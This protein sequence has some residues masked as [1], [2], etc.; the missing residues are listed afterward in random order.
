MSFHKISVRSNSDFTPHLAWNRISLPLFKAFKKAWL[1]LT[2]FRYIY[3]CVIE[4]LECRI[5]WPKA[6]LQNSL[7]WHTLGLS[8]R[9]RVWSESIN[10]NT[11]CREYIHDPPGNY[12][13][14]HCLV[15]FYKTFW[16]LYFLLKNNFSCFQV[17]LWH[18]HKFL[19][20]LNR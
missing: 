15:G 18:I 11:G 17:H 5:I 10:V 7:S 13:S 20:S 9:I 4:F 1:K 2:V 16:K 6:S 14:L 12:W 19:F 8:F 3:F